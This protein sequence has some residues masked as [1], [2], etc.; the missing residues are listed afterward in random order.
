MKKTILL[1]TLLASLICLVQAFGAPVLTPTVK[2][3]PSVASGVYIGIPRQQAVCLSTADN[4]VIRWSGNTER[5]WHTHNAG[6]SWT[7]ITGTMPMTSI[8]DHFA[9][10][11]DTTYIGTGSAAVDPHSWDFTTINPDGSLN[12]VTRFTDATAF[13]NDVY[14]VIFSPQ[15]ASNGNDMVAMARTADAG[16]YWY[17]SR[18]R[19]RSWLY[20]G[21][22]LNGGSTG[23]T[24]PSYTGSGR[25][26][27]TWNPPDTV[28][29]AVMSPP[30]VNVYYYKPHDTTWVRH[31][32]A[33]FN[34]SDIVRPTDGGF[35]FSSIIANGTTYLIGPATASGN[36]GRSVYHVWSSPAYGTGTPTQVTLD[37]HSV[38]VATDFVPYVALQEIKSLNAVMAY[39]RVPEA[40][41]GSSMYC[42][43]LYDGTWTDE[44]QLDTAN[45][46]NIAP[47]F[48]VPASHGDR[49]YLLGN[50]ASAGYVIVVDVT[51]I[52]EDSILSVTPASL[53]FGN[54]AR[55]SSPAD[56]VFVVKNSGGGTLSGTATGLSAPFSV[57]S[58][59]TYSHLETDT[60][61]VSVRF[62]PTSTGSFTD[63]VF[64]SGASGDTMV[65][66]G[67]GTVATHLLW[68]KP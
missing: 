44:I 17:L 50:S 57:E 28:M 40:D 35:I 13:P 2:S 45:F 42:R 39:Y 41:S 68:R 12:N 29:A 18:D 55:N 58:G 26:G 10:W 65:V 54:V 36:P 62:R 19:G 14:S 33:R 49:G 56:R 48:Q 53:A 34:T 64:F 30:D 15:S 7:E 11:D 22:Y 23:G 5:F 32:S 66:T 9:V 6:E 24:F 8:H 46:T 61:V 47:P 60:N 52:E 1:L 16:M 67:T 63:S 43:M 38:Y 37:S 25:M 20:K 59:G 31:G 21:N 51:G 3:L 27:L 4:L